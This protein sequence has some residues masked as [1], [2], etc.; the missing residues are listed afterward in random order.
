M[1]DFIDFMRTWVVAHAEFLLTWLIAVL[2]VM[3][4]A[5]IEIRRGTRRAAIAMTEA[6]ATTV[7]ACVPEIAAAAQSGQPAGLA[8]AAS[9][10]RLSEALHALSRLSAARL[11]WLHLVANLRVP[12]TALPA[13]APEAPVH[14]LV[15]DTP[16][17]LAEVHLAAERC[18]AEHVRALLAE[19]RALQALETAER[20]GRD[21]LQRIER[22]TSAIVVRFEQANAQSE[23]T[24][25]QRF[26]IQKFNA[27]GTRERELTTH[28]AAL[29]QQLADRADGLW[30]QSQ[31]AAEDYTAMLDRLI[32]AVRHELGHEHAVD[33][34]ALWLT[35]T[36]TGQ[37]PLRAA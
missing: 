16:R 24:E 32:A 11:H 14:P 3:L 19:R 8:P 20:D 6:V 33:E 29:R 2:V 27:L 26:L 1:M 30:V 36:R 7:A 4:V 5:W 18:F 17:A 31:R 34:A 10:A 12:D 15:Y 22:E 25:V 23:Q 9:T 28:L 35:R 37:G 13:A 21:E